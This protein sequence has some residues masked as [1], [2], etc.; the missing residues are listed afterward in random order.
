MRGVVLAA[1]LAGCNFSHGVLPADAPGPGDDASDAANVLDDAAIDAPPELCFGTDPITICFEQPLTT[2]L[3]V[4]TRTI[5]TGGTDCMAYTSPQSVDA[6]VLAG[7]SIT[8]DAGVTLT[9][10]GE[11]PLILVSASTI[12]IAGGGTVDVASRRG[13][14]LGAGADM[15]GCSDGTAPSGTVSQVGGGWGGSFGAKGGDGGDGSGDNGGKASAAIVPAT[16]RGGCPGSDGANSDVAG[17]RGHGGGAVAL[18][19]KSAIQIAGIVNASGSAGGGGQ[20]GVG[21]SGGG[22]GGGS[23]GMIRLDAMTVTVSGQVFA[24]GGGGGEGA[25]SSNDGGAGLE[26]TAPG[27]A[28]AG[29][30]GGAGSGGDGGS[31]SFADMIGGFTGANGSNISG[32]GGGGGGSA[33]VIQLVGTGVGTADPT[34]VAPPP[35]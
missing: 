34:I 33:G 24:N 19:A 16:L 31:G 27:G 4:T 6:C 23:G 10:Q 25:S 21:S 7:S 3:V 5:D 1:S 32:S 26:S 9:G 17:G 35:T 14:P 15:P 12:T 28:G 2:P 29:G 13:Q 30:S 22:G 18:I 11:K 20:Q 8:I